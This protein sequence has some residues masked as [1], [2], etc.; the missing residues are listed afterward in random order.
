MRGPLSPQLTAVPSFP[1]CSPPLPAPLFPRPVAEAAPMNPAQVGAA[2]PGPP[3]GVTLAS[4][5]QMRTEGSP[6]SS[7]RL[8]PRVQS[9]GRPWERSPFHP[10]G[11]SAGESLLAAAFE[12]LQVLRSRQH[13]GNPGCFV[14]GRRSL[15]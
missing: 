1:P 2:S 4:E 8:S 12:R 5:D 13:W 11:G 7:L 3:P 9:R 15:P 6:V 10:V 14:L